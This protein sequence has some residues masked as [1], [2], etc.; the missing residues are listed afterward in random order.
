MASLVSKFL[1]SESTLMML[2]YQF[3]SFCYFVVSVKPKV[4]TTIA[5]QVGNTRENRRKNRVSDGCIRM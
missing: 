4:G 5:P 1:L 3:N 2:M